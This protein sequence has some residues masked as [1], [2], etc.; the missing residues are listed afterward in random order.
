MRSAMCDGDSSTE[1]NVLLI[2][3][4]SSG[5]VAPKSSSGGY[6]THR[7]HSHSCPDCTVS[8]YISTT[9]A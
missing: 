4:S 9:M 7:S 2:D 1:S 5:A 8:C 6:N 3:D